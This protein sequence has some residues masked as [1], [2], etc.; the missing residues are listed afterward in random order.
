LNVSKRLVSLTQA[1]WPMAVLD[2]DSLR[3][4]LESG[5]TPEQLRA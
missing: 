2:V 5:R 4:L 3:Q 1:I